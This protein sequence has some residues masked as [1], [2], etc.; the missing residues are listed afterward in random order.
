MWTFCKKTLSMNVKE[1]SMI[2][3]NMVVKTISCC[4]KWC[5]LRKSILRQSK[6][7]TSLIVFSG[8]LC[9]IACQWFRLHSRRHGVHLLP[10]YIT[11]PI[12][13]WVSSSIEC[14]KIEYCGDVCPIGSLE[15]RS[16]RVFC[17]ELFAK[18]WPITPKSWESSSWIVRWVIVRRKT[19]WKFQRMTLCLRNWDEIRY[20]AYKI[21]VC[22]HSY[23]IP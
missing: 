17:H 4:L 8:I 3:R 7:S 20:V 6:G 19:S 9:W 15:A 13:W 21:L 23:V 12:E 5:F 1:L 16:G 18:L 14:R 22:S 2:S 11:L 10:R